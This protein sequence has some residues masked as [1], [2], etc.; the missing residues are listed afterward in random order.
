MK[1]THCFAV[2]GDLQ[3]IIDVVNPE[4]GRSSIYGHT[5]E[6]VQER[7]P[8]AVVMLLDDFMEAKAKEQNAPLKWRRISRARYWEMLEVLPPAAW[9]SGAFLVGEPTDYC[10]KTGRPRFSVFREE[11]GSISENHFEGSRPITFAEFKEL[12]PKAKYTYTE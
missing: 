9:S 3:S 2:P 1:Y 11:K 12:R 4:T 6:Q 8:G 7:D 10:A 5:L